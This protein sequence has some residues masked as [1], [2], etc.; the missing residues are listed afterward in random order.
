MR[1][2]DA[3]DAAL[4]GR[5]LLLH[6]GL[7][8]GRGEH[9][10]RRS[11]CRV[12]VPFPRA[13]ALADGRAR[14]PRHRR[15]RTGRRSRCASGLDL[16]LGARV[17][18][19]SKD[20]TLDHVLHA[21]H[22]A[23]DQRRRRSVV[24]ERVAASVARL[25]PAARSHGVCARSAPDTSPADSI[26]RRRR[27]P[28]RTARSTPGRSKAASKTTWAD[29]RVLANAALFYIDWD[30][31]QLNLPNPQ[32]PA[33]FYIANVGGARSTRRRTRTERPR[34]RRV[35]PVRRDR[36]H[37]RALQGRQRLERRRRVR[38]RSAEHA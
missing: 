3:R 37:E 12:Q 36:L 14:R 2:S 21:G 34:G 15:L 9:A 20:A 27:A 6:A 5:R 29:G 11:C 24:L 35:R 28:K 19:E 31:L 10:T 33:Q 17:D 26:P 7:R 13:A 16:T 1:L 32:V 4:A 38:Q 18:Y 23:A 30:D 8:S 22:R 25:S